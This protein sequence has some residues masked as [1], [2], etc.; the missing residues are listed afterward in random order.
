ML[1]YR[2]VSGKSS[3]TEQNISY[4]YSWGYIDIYI[5][6]FPREGKRKAAVISSSRYDILSIQKQQISCKKIGW[7]TYFWTKSHILVSQDVVK[8]KLSEN[9]ACFCW[10][11][12]EIKRN[13]SFVHLTND[14][15]R[16]T[17]HGCFRVVFFLGGKSCFL[18][19]VD[20][21]SQVP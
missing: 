17:R 9:P 18:L 13:R 21:R 2:R 6:S 7:W 19:G 12:W 3:S 4:L 5:C 11:C 20:Q 15:P 14:V 8:W 10:D 16:S 1:V